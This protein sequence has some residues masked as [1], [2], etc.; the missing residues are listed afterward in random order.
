LL[1]PPYAHLLL[2]VCVEYRQL[3]DAERVTGQV[4]TAFLIPDVSLK[5]V[6]KW[7]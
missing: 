5:E 1:P 3:E 6:R 2:K 7:P 4:V